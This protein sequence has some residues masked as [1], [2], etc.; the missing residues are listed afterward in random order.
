MCI[1][2]LCTH[3]QSE[4]VP[5]W[6]CDVMCCVRSRHSFT[7]ACARANCMCV[8][9]GSCAYIS[10]LSFILNTHTCSCMCYFF[11]D[12]L[13]ALL[14]WPCALTKMQN[15]TRKKTELCLCVFEMERERKIGWGWGVPTLVHGWLRHLQWAKWKICMWFEAVDMSS[16][17]AV[18]V[19]YNARIS[20][21]YFVQAPPTEAFRFWMREHWTHTHPAKWFQCQTMS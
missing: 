2:S 12:H 10:T 6:L 13:C 21:I 9:F 4:N 5:S 17:C 14:I 19:W 1:K 7:W 16:K 3:F 18:V 8:F 20:M 11:L 15:L